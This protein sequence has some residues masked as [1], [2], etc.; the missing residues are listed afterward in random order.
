ME[1]ATRH[2]TTRAVVLTLAVTILPGLL[3]AGSVPRTWDAR[4]ERWADEA[5]AEGVRPVDLHRVLLALGWRAMLNDRRVADRLLDQLTA[6]ATDPLVVDRLR[7]WRARLALEEGRPEAARELFRTGGGLE[8]WWAAGPS[9]IEELSDLDTLGPVPPLGDWRRVFGTDATGWVNLEGIAWP[10]QRQVLYLATTVEAD[11]RRTVA[12]RLGAAGAARLWVDGR[13]VLETPHPIVRGEDQFAGGARLGAG[14]HVVVVAVAVERGEWWLRLRLTRPD[15]GPLEGVREVDARPVPVPAAPAEAAP[16]EVGTLRGVLEKAV[17]SNVPGARIALAAL[18]VETRPEAVGSGVERAACRDAREEAPALARWFEWLVTDEPG[19]RRDLLR[20]IVDHDP[21]FLPA[22]VELALWLHRRGLHEE[23]HGVAAAASAEQGAAVATA[24][25]LD[26]DL[27]GALALPGLRRASARFPDCVRLLS[28]LASRSMDGERWAMARRAVAELQRLVPGARGTRALAGRLAVAGGDQEALL[29]LIRSRLDADPNDLEARLRLARLAIAGGDTDRAVRL[30]GEGAARCPGHPRLTMD[31]AGLEH[32]LGHDAEAVRLARSVLEKRPQDR[33]AQRFLELL[34]SDTEDRSWVRQP[35]DLRSMVPLAEKAALEGPWI[36]LLDHHEVRFLPG[37]LTEERVQQVF[38]VRDPERSD[39][40]RQRT[41]AVVP[42]R[43]RLRVLAARILRGDG[44]ISAEQGTT[45]RLSEPEFNLYYDTR[46][47]VLRFPRFEEGDLVEVTYLLTETAESNDTGAYR[48]GIIMLAGP[49]PVLRTEVI[50]DAPAGSMPAWEVAGMRLEPRR[51]TA[52]GRE[53]LLFFRKATAAVPADIPP[54]PLLEVTPHLVYSTRPQWGDLAAWYERHV[55]PRLRSSEETRALVRRLTAD[56]PGRKETIRVLYRYVTDQIRYVGLEFGEHRFRPFSPDW[57]IRHRMGDC[58]DKAALL[59]TLL[60]EA[61]IP[62]RMVLLRTANLGPVVSRMAIL[63]DFNHAIAYLPDDG[64]WLDGTASGNDMEAIPGLD[65]NAWALVVDG[66]GSKPQTTPSGPA[67]ERTLHFVIGASP[68]P[69]E[70][71]P[72]SVSETSTGDAAQALRGALAG[73][74]DPKRF[75][76]WFQSW[77]PGG[78]VEGTP[79]ATLEPGTDP[80]MVSVSGEVPGSA[81]VAGR[82]LR[83]YPGTLDLQRHLTP[84]ET[85]H[86]PLLLTSRPRLRWTVEV[87]ASA[88][89]ALPDSEHLESPWG[90]F[91]LSAERTEA[92]Y[93]VEGTLELEPG[94]VPADRIP[95][96]RSMLGRI[97]RAADQRLEVR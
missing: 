73:S 6:A 76:R 22:R 75:E 23:A 42:E 67:G 33:R 30:L 15:G 60:R 80:A 78:A 66:P 44:E 45:P 18:L 2:R 48:G 96:F 19:D 16:P 29:G 85:R 4:C 56:S 92:G 40:L 69:G 53:R 34:G 51:E 1:D 5:A 17:D 64:L 12:F 50:L 70:P 24:L 72:A 88:A 32:V 43:Q 84:T 82:G 52:K 38:L 55:E 97:D 54:P 57:V 87:A 83:A 39:P 61:G 37:N 62:A 21:D 3:G 11:A 31:Y 47:R 13:P 81:L 14:R 94:L 89:A 7:S 25:D 28:I 93:R 68:K 26:A 27:W 74:Q 35:A 58:K 46:L 63:E 90:R 71:R 95:E 79:R 36:R 8:R 59:V 86:S 49:E 41:I 77:F 9:P 91:D 20:W 10:T 65:R